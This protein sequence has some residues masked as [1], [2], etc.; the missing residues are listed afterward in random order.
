MD[1]TEKMPAAEIR[2]RNWFSVTWQ[3][4]TIFISMLREANKRR[5]SYPRS[6]NPWSNKVCYLSMN[7]RLCLKED[8]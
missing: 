7:I 6:S 4:I 3:M 8:E 1:A 2:G 5:L